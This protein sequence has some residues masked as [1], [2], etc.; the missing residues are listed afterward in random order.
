MINICMVLMG[1]CLAV[2][3]IILLFSGFPLPGQPGLLY[4]VGA[5]WAMTSF[6]MLFFRRRPLATTVLGCLL[7]AVNAY[8]L[9]FHSNE[10]KSVPWFLYQHSV[11][12]AFIAFSCIGFALLGR[13]KKPTPS[14]QM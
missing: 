7:L 11:E 8:D 6:S 9:W 13:R 14:P 4:A 10:E 2:E 12:I 3:G 1:I 5:L